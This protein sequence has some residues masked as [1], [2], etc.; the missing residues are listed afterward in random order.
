M[1][2]LRDLLDPEE[3]DAVC[4]MIDAAIAN[5]GTAPTDRKSA[6]D[7]RI[8]GATNMDLDVRFKVPTGRVVRGV[9]RYEAALAEVQPYV[10][11]IRLA[12]DSVDAVYKTALKQLGHDVAELKHEGA[13]S[14]LWPLLK[15]RKPAQRRSMATDAKAA[16]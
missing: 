3:Y 5:P 16:A 8:T 2:T 1:D 9:Q 12:C 7:G 11:D 15:T 4:G 14:A 13:A 10:G 6:A